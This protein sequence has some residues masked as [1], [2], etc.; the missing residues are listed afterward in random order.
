[1]E[2]ATQRQCNP[3]TEDRNECLDVGDGSVVD[4]NGRCGTSEF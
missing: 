4:G 2:W 1:M 3:Y